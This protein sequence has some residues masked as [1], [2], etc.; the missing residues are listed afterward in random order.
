[1]P[2][3]TGGRGQADAGFISELAGGVVLL[4][5]AESLTAS[6][7]QVGAAGIPLYDFQS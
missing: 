6:E 5:P 2:C 7:L 1:M 3:R 4:G